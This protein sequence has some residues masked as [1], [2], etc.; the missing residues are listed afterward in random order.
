[1]MI[2]NKISRI[3]KKWHDTVFLVQAPKN[4][5]TDCAPDGTQSDRETPR[6]QREKHYK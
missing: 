3:K 2:C 6:S 1:M 4:T 5:S